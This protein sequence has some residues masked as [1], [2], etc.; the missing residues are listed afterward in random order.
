MGE[1]LSTKRLHTLGV[2]A[3]RVSIVLTLQECLEIVG[4]NS[5]ER[6]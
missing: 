2:Y 3:I 4:S 5:E 1:L 6:L